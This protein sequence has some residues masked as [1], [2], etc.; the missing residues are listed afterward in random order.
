MKSFLKIISLGVIAICMASSCEKKNYDSY[1][2]SWLG[3]DVPASVQAGQTITARAV[4]AEKG[5]LINATTYKWTLY[6]ERASKKD[7]LTNIVRTNYDGTDNSDPT[8]TITIPADARPGTPATLLFEA[9]YS[10]SG[11][12]VE[13]PK[14]PGSTQYRSYINSSSGAMSGRANGS[15]SMAVVAP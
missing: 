3:F 15:V 10:Y 4:Q 8:W 2:P 13:G 11:G 6:V 7:T 9:S 5:R 12:G 14:N 1:P